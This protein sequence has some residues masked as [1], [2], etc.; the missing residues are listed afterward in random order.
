[1]FN[2]P[3]L[4][5]NLLSAL[6]VAARPHPVPRRHR[7]ASSRLPG[8]AALREQAT[9]KPTVA[10]GLRTPAPKSGVMPSNPTDPHDPRKPQLSWGAAGTGAERSGADGSRRRCAEQQEAIP[11]GR[12][13]A[14]TPSETGTLNNT[15]NP[16]VCV[17][18]LPATAGWPG[19]AQPCPSGLGRGAAALPPPTT[20]R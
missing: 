9:H 19:A 7:S 15:N 2:P 4:R 20:A 17:T 8:A 10:L 3:R 11:G 14:A 6:R 12:D 1:M 16:G 13:G 18:L 5:C